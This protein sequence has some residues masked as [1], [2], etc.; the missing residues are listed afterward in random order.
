MSRED[1]RAQMDPNL[2]ERIRARW[3]RI[4]IARSAKR[5]DELSE[6]WKQLPPNWIEQRLLEAK[7]KEQQP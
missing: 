4:L 2:V 6:R 1:R 7:R 5:T 3:A